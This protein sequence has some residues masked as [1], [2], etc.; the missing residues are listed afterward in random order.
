MCPIL[1]MKGATMARTVLNGSLSNR[2]NCLN[3]SWSS[4]LIN[5]KDL[6]MLLVADFSKSI[7][8]A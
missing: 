7:L 8:C 4:T 1:V 3:A 6:G 2:W 5:V